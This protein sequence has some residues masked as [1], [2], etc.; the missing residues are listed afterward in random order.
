MNYA[1]KSMKLVQHTKLN[2]ALQ[3]ICCY[4]KV[5]CSHRRTKTSE[6]KHKPTAFIVNLKS[7]ST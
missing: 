3:Q 4:N 7:V 6:N 1:G 2:Q 5:C